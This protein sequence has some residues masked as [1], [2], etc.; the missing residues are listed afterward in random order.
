MN[1][2]PVAVLPAIDPTKVRQVLEQKHDRPLVAC[3]YHP[4][5]RQVFFGAEDNYVHRFDLDGKNEVPLAGHDSWVRAIGFSPDGTTLYT[6]GYDGR[7]IWWPAAA[8]NPKPTRV[9]D[10]HAGWVRALAVGGSSPR[11]V[12]TC[13]ND[14]LIK[15]WNPETGSLIAE[16]RGHTQQVYNLVVASDGETLISCDLKGNLKEWNTQTGA[17]KRDLSPAATLYKYDTTFRADIGG[18]RSIALAGDGKQLALGGITNV[19]NAFA[20]IGNA[21]IVLV[22]L[23]DG[24]VLRQLEAEQKVNG[25]A[26]GVAWHPAGFWIGLA[27]G[28]GGGW[29]YFF[30]PDATSEFFKFKLPNDGRDLSLSPDGRHVAV[31]HADKSLRIYA[32]FA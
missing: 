30:K 15:L 16:C 28:G 24:K 23:E 14:Q 4:T 2:P 11:F 8:A 19:T 12:A 6:G 18:S 5:G 10:A 20:G 21:A 9:V 1:D 17:L 13:G 31:A 22:N 29:L 7:L 25:V 3:R 27:G 32:L 26:W